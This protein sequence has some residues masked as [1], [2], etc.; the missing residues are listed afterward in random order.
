[1]SEEMEVPVETPKRKGGRPRGPAKRQGEGTFTKDEMKDF[2]TH[3]ISESKKP[4]ELDQK[5][6]DEEQRRRVISAK[7]RADEAFRTAEEKRQQIAFCK[8]RR[9]DD[10][11][12]F[13][14]HV[15]SDG[16]IRGTCV[17]C[18]YEFGPIKATEDQMKEGGGVNL[19]M[20]PDLTAAKLDAWTAKT[21]TQYPEAT[22]SQPSWKIA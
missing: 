17:R 15:C 16:F 1:M 12:T 13:Q 7:A 3:L 2:M 11:H 21:R 10:K 5:K 6:L 8:H 19:H 9:P 22:V 4:S 18:P 14:G 20:V